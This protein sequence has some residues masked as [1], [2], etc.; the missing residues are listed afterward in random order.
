MF[1]FNKIKETLQDNVVSLK[2]KAGKIKESAIKKLQRKIPFDEV[3][4]EVRKN[5][6][7]SWYEEIYNKNKDTLDDVAIFYRGTEI[8]YGE[9]FDK[10]KEYA[11]SLKARG[12][13]KGTEIP[14]CISNT[15]ELIYILGAISMVGAQANIFG[16]EFDKD[17]ITEI[18]DGCNANF[19]FVEDEQYEKIKDSIK[20]SHINDIVMTSLTDSLPNGKSPY[21]KYDNMHGKFVRKV[22]EYQA[23]N[24]NISNLNEFTASGKNYKGQLLEKSGLD[25]VFTTTYSSGSTNSSRPKAIVHK[26]S[27]FIVMGRY[28]DKEVA[29]IPPMKNLTMM[30]L[31]PTH[32]NSD[33]IGTI[34]DGLM[35]GSRM[36]LEPIYDEKFFPYALMINKPN[37]ALGT[38]GFWTSFFK[39]VM[40]DPKFA[41]VRMPQMIFPFAVGEPYSA[42][43]EKF[44]NKA[45]KKLKAGTNFTFANRNIKLPVSPTVMSVAGGDCEHGAIFIVIFRALQSKMPHCLRHKHEA[46]LTTYNMV[47]YA[48]LD[49][50]GKHCG[51]YEYGRLVANSPCTMKEYKNNPESTAKFFIK[52]AD[53]KTWADCNVYGFIDSKNGIH[54]K[55]RIPATKEDIPGFMIADP[56]LKD[57]KNILS[58]EVVEPNDTKD[59]YVAHIEFMPKKGNK[60]RSYENIFKSLYSAEQRIA[61]ELGEDVASKV[62]YRIHSFD[63]SYPL[64][65]CGKRDNKALKAEGVNSICIKPVITENGCEFMSA[66]EYLA[67]RHVKTL[68]K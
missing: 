63:E 26:N 21:E 56:V 12:V 13:E 19:M 10:M 49:E 37:F 47:D 50:E 58:C 29:G 65:A 61:N 64:T 32:S 52:D 59:A 28:H 27:S 5:R 31:I 33:I 34:S 39:K 9:M 51:P 40:Y 57:T 42:G 35:Q 55:G 68:K 14:I 20:N 8:T 54:M 36:A 44:A 60:E 45:L 46:G 48:V 62:V 67:A 22:V 30:A 17:Y 1:N 2:T 66:K 24:P 3:M 25:D 7:H 43:E 11:K 16:A 4:A 18:I 15:P 23:E 6:D 38:R 41:N 53:G